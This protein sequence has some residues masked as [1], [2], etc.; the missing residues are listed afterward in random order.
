[1]YFKLDGGGYSNMRLPCMQLNYSSLIYVNGFAFLFH[2]FLCCWPKKCN[3]PVYIYVCVVF[4]SFRPR[5]TILNLLV[6]LYV[7]VY[8]PPHPLPPALPL[9]TETPLLLPHHHSLPPSLP[10]TTSTAA[11]GPPLLPPTDTPAPPA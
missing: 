10:Q 2:K 6:S 9:P 1:M 7:C 8:N 4:K 11:P 3:L 5:L